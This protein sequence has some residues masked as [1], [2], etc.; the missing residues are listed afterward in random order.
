V[1]W[2]RLKVMEKSQDGFKIAE[3]DL[4]FRGSGDFFGVKQ[5]GLPQLKIGNILRD[6]KILSEA[7][8]AAFALIKRDPNL[9]KPEHAELRRALTE[10]WRERFELGDIG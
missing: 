8:K 7:R 6:H 4:Q 3:A 1:A 10:R 5:S 2:D 9:S